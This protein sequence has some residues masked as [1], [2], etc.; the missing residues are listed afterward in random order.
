[1]MLDSKQSEEFVSVLE[2][3]GFNLAD[4]EFLETL[5]QAEGLSN[6]QMEDLETLRKTLREVSEKYG[7]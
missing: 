6:S 4:W 7:V 1:M 3:N 5:L 2:E